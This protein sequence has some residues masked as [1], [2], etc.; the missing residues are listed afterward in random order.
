MLRLWLLAG[1]HLILLRIQ[2]K[3]KYDYC[4]QYNFPET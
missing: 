1:L 2:G 4:R 3:R